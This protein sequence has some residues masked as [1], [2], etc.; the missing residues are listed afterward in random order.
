MTNCL[1]CVN[2]QG[3]NNY[4][5][6]QPS[7]AEQ[8]AIIKKEVLEGRGK[9][10]LQHFQTLQ[11]SQILSA[12]ESV[13]CEGCLG[14]SLTNTKDTILFFE[15]GDNEHCKY[16]FSARGTKNSLD[17]YAIE[18]GNFC[19]ECISGSHNN[20][21][22]AFNIACGECESVYY[23]NYCLSCHHCFGCVGLRNQSY[24]ILNKQYTKEEYER[25]VTQIIEHMQRTGER[26]EF[27][28]PSLSPF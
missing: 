24:C 14:G 28:H 10:Y 12:T 11:H 7:T 22:C 26:G 8:I 19:Y 21:K 20:M 25:R 1:F 16:G 23:S 5:F 13:S 18:H 3:K 4:L 9:H 17:I 15:S 6:N 2:I 27:F